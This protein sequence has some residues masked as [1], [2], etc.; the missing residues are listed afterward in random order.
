[1]NRHTRRRGLLA[2]YMVLALCGCLVSAETIDIGDSMQ[3]LIEADWIDRDCYLAGSTDFPTDYTR[4]LITQGL[5]LAERLHRIS[6]PK[7]SLEP[8]TNKLRRLETRMVESGF[9]FDERRNTYLDV[10][11][12]IRRIAFC[13]P[14]LNFDK[15]LFIKRHHP[16]GVFHMCD[17][18][19]GCNAIPGGG[20]LILTD[21]FGANPKLTNMLAGSVVEEGR[22]EG[23]RLEPGGFLSPELS[24]D[25]KTILFAYTQAKAYEKYRGKE[26]YEWDPEISYHIF[27]VNTD[28]TGLVQLTDDP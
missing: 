6:A 23:R 9:S 27:K 14:L 20:L 8:L 7:V 24:Y 10:R 22:L 15:I 13:N 28:G 18:Y 26:A 2:A 5:A 12:T 16:G 3:Q 17:Q 21:P 25:A 1:M 11:R 4:Q 19:Y